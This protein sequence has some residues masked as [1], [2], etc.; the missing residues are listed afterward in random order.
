MIR[1]TV[2][3]IDRTLIAPE[4]GVL[5]RETA[6]AVRHLQ[7]K[8]I[9]TA[10]ASGRLLRMIQPE[11]RQLGFDYFILSNGAY[12][13]DSTGAVLFQETIDTALIDEL[14]QEMIRRGHPI[15]L[16]YVDGMAPGNPNC[17]M[18]QMMK[19]FWSKMNIVRRPS[20]DLLQEFKAPE[21]ALPV[22]CSGYIPEEELPFFTRKFPQLDFLPVFES[23]LCDINKAGVSKATG[24]EKICSLTGISMSQTIAFGDDRN[25]VEMVAAA[26]IGVAMGNAI[27][28]VKDAADYQ[29]DTCEDLGVVTALRHFGLLD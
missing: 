18:M 11:L 12:V 5:A 27:Q 25:D 9:K 6:D 16:R 2:F 14:V 13:A 20:K 24:V 15:D 4:Q 21:G 7:Q 23:P 26:G 17:S 22:A 19:D 8:G 28:A 3:D 1:L 10:I 29:T